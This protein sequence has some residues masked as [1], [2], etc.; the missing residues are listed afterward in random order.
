MKKRTNL[1][2][3]LGIVT[4]LL[5][6]SCETETFDLDS[7]VEEIQFTEQGMIK[8]NFNHR[9]FGE[10]SGIHS[11]NIIISWNEYKTINIEDRIWYE[12]NVEE[13]IKPE[14]EAGEITDITYSLLVTIVDKSPAYW[15]VRMDSHNGVAFDSYFELEEGNFTGMVYLFDIEGTV[16]MARFYRKGEAYQ[17][18]KDIGNTTNLP[19]PEVAR[20]DAKVVARCTVQ[21][22]CPPPQTGTGGCKYG[23]GHY[24][25][26]ISYSYTDWYLD[27]N[28]DG[29]GQANEYYNTT[30]Q[31]TRTYV[32]VPSGT[33]LPPSQNSWG[34]AALDGSGQ[35]SSIPKPRVQPERII[36]APDLLEGYPCTE[37]IIGKAL[38]AELDVWGTMKD[39]FGND[40]SDFDIT[41]KHKVLED[42][43]EGRL[44][45]G[46]THV[47]LANSRIS[48][49]TIYLN[50]TYLNLATDVSIFATV[51]HENVHAL[52]LY[53]LDQKGI[54]FDNP[55]NLDMAILADKWSAEVAKIQ[56]GPMPPNDLAYAQHRIMVGVVDVM[57]D[58]IQTFA[59]T[60]NYGIDEIQAE[61]L[62]WTGL[63][64]SIAWTLMDPLVKE[65][66]ENL[67]EYETTGFGPLAIGTKCD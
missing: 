16:D 46:E 27:R 43:R 13:I 9:N 21:N 59:T 8:S 57:A 34:F 41:Y 19:Q 52:M 24:E 53:Q 63:F 26:Q 20:C 50:T 30:T 58:Y 3:F 4:A 25:W 38:S 36:I 60:R 44:T 56:N 31:E 18:V 5:I 66:I 17:G 40:D 11:E 55:E 49:M 42:D 28:G 67:I 39:A 65:S 14:L 35:V 54:V 47:T 62:A 22:G 15:L 6:I 51:L 29:V 1:Y 32:F 23:G 2:L 37:G 45:L 61:A 7:M 10:Y 33:S 48:D 12:Y 64:D